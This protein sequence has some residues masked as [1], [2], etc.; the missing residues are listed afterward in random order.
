MSNTRGIFA[1]AM[2]A[3]MAACAPTKQF[4][5]QDY[6]VDFA[7]ALQFAGKAQLAYDPADTVR[8]ACGRDSCYIFQGRQTGA[9]AFAQVDD[10]AQVQWISF[11]GTKLL[12]DV[13]LDGDFSQT[14]NVNLGKIGRASCRERVCQYV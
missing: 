6:R 14:E 10:S 5:P 3:L 13:K 12:S 8:A 1:C 11:R 4:C 2:G 7:E 9:G